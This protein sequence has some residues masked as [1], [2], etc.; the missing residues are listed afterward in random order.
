MN[1][2]DPKQ[3]SCRAFRSEFALPTPLVHELGRVLVHKQCMT[4]DPMEGSTDKLGVSHSTRVQPAPLPD[5]ADP[6][7]H[8]TRRRDSAPCE[9]W[10]GVSVVHDRRRRPIFF[11]F[12]ICN[13]W[14][15]E[16][17]ESGR[18]SRSGHLKAKLSNSHT[19]KSKSQE[20]S[21]T[22][23]PLPNSQRVRTSILHSNVRAKIIETTATAIT[24]SCYGYYCYSCYWSH[25]NLPLFYGDICWCNLKV[26]RP[27]LS[28]G[29]DL[30][31]FLILLLFSTWA[32]LDLNAV[33]T[34]LL[35]SY[36]TDRWP[37]DQQKR[38]SSSRERERENK[39]RCTLCMCMCVNVCMYICMYKWYWTTET[40][41]ISTLLVHFIHTRL[42][43]MTGD[44]CHWHIFKISPKFQPPFASIF[45]FR[46]QWQHIVVLHWF[47]DL[48]PVPS[49]RLLPNC[50]Y[51]FVC[52]VTKTIIDSDRTSHP[53]APKSACWNE[54]A[55][56]FPTVSVF[57]YGS[58]CQSG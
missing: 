5:E 14:L 30:T 11:F 13:C 27:H 39:R 6:K 4:F 21:P 31:S 50:H 19:A 12:F 29:L 43:L 28:E 22:A 45:S 58:L 52:W 9:P 38:S 24:V 1:D 7:M 35:L 36:L 44:Y 53:T 16:W 23:N 25:P 34:V 18:K 55:F 2:C 46:H 17:L 10:S 3:L 20:P 56:L 51:H 47:P 32:T 41:A 33:E 40:T 57:C 54:N 37:K 8:H 15:G 42:F 48:S 26:T 49:N